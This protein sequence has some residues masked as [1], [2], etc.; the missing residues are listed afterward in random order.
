MKVKKNIIVDIKIYPKNDGTLFLKLLSYSGMIKTSNV[1]YNPEY[2]WR[3]R[4]N[5]KIIVSYDTYLSCEYANE[6]KEKLERT[7]SE[8]KNNHCNIL[9]IAKIGVSDFSIVLS[10]NMVI[11][12][13]RVSILD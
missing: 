9:E 3:I 10:N 11:D 13:F 2:I 4:K 6:E 1:I 5:S 8:I 7:F 12:F